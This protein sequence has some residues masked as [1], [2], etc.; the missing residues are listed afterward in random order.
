MRL[1]PVVLDL[2]RQDRTEVEIVGQRLKSEGI[3]ITWTFARL[4]AH[5][6]SNLGWVHAVVAVPPDQQEYVAGEL[7]DA[8]LL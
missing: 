8:G 6:T 3:A 2:G 1:E 7:R 4:N 5:G